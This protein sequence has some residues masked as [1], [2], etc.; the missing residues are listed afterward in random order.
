M[1]LDLVRLSKSDKLGDIYVFHHKN[2]IIHLSIDDIAHRVNVFH[3]NEDIL[4]RNYPSATISRHGTSLDTK[5]RMATSR[6]IDNYIEILTEYKEAVAHGEEIF[7]NRQEII[8]KYA[9]C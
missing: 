4:T 7:K 6:D 5:C 9:N 2:Y 8:S 1:M 3:K